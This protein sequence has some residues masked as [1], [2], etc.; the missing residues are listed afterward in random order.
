MAKEKK[1]VKIGIF[2]LTGCAG[3]QLSIIDCEKE[4]VSL[5]TD[6][7]IESFVMAK[8]D[9]SHGELDVALVEGSV[10]TEI[11]KEEL[12]DIRK[13]SQILIA[14]GTC[15]CTGG[16]QGANFNLEDWKKKIDQ[17]YGKVEWSHTKPLVSS[18]LDAYV[19]VDYY[20]PGCPISREQF[21]PTFTRL[22][23]LTPPDLGNYP[24]CIECKWKE[25]DCLL[26]KGLPCMGPLT[27]AG[28]GAICPSNNL[29]CVGCWGP[30]K[31]PNREAMAVLLKLKGYNQD[32]IIRKMS[33]FSGKNIEKISQKLK[34]AWK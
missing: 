12:E 16:V 8:S 5:F 7:Q 20:L 23:N 14:M 25:N 31:E 32:F 26:N 21:L 3:C 4:L 10:S 28:C 30:S 24:C 27:A 2:G 22:A 33:M 29:P 1:K 34:E 19:K 11:E 15:A 6:A 17:V 13:R 9:N 18:P